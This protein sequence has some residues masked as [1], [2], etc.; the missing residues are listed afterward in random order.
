VITPLGPA[1]AV[2]MVAEPKALDTHG[3]DGARTQSALT[4]A[5]N[6]AEQANTREV[7][8]NDDAQAACSP[9]AVISMRHYP[10]TT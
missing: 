9:P 1:N 3:S 10:A 6:Q 4:A 5:I 8:V 2:Y 7:E